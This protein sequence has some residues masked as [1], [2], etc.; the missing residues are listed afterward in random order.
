[1]SKFRNPAALLAATAL[2]LAA[3][4]SP[5]RAAAPAAGTA[6]NLLSGAPSLV[7]CGPSEPKSA[8]GVVTPLGGGKIAVGGFSINL[9]AGAVLAPTTLTV[10]V[11]AS[12]YVEVSIRA[13]GQEHFEFLQTALVTLSYAGC[14]DP[15][16]DATTLE[17]WYVDEG[18]KTPIARMISVDNKAAR[19]VTFATNHLSGYALANRTGE[20]PT[21]TTGT[22]PE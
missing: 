8:S 7:S 11:P 14:T 4:A 21:D 9:P 17:A 22:T 19:S 1:M 2:T 13:D 15:A 6:L 18:T 12:P 10:T 5:D 20:T 3:C 16:L